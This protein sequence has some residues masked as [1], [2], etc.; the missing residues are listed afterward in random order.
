MSYKIDVL[1]SYTEDDNIPSGANENGWVS[2]FKY[3]L[4]LMLE[5]VIGEK[6]TVLMRSEN[7]TLT[8]NNLDDVAIFMPIMSPFFLASSPCQDLLAEFDKNQKK[9]KINRIFKIMKTPLPYHRQPECI[10][11]NLGY[12]LYKMDMDT[13]VHSDFR[14]YFDDEAAGSYW[15]HIVDIS[16][17]IHDSLFQMA[18]RTRKTKSLNEQRSVYLAE[19]AHDLSIQ[20]NIIKRELQRHGY[21]I[22]PDHSLPTTYPEVED[23]IRKIITEADLSIHLIGTSYGEIPSGSEKSVIDI[24]V[25]LAAEK[26]TNM[27]QYAFPRLIW[28]TP[29]LKLASEKQLTFIENV[30]RASDVAEGT[31][32]LQTPLEDFK[33]IIREDVIEGGFER[34]R[35]QNEE[36]NFDNGKSIYLI[37]DKIDTNKAQEVKNNLQK[38]GFEILEPKFDGDLMEI[39]EHHIDNLKKF[40]AAIVY[41]NEVNRQWVRMKVLDLMKAPGFGRTKPMKGRALIGNTFTG[42]ESFENQGIT[43][44]DNDQ[45]LS[46]N[47]ESFIEDIK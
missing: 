5:Q 26:A 8:G 36:K 20:R 40:D 4:E 37:H 2:D 3:F 27:S 21:K 31:E 13:G 38:A 44:I 45:N 43:L 23:E 11:D 39:R 29:N 9:S 17:D 46:I 14:E 1:I 35:A 32:I 30:K 7:D 33:N 22:L 10:R 16:F 24:Q 34:K 28:I 6:P 12:D 47:L 15:M 19:T 41:Q 25:S 42:L 18:G